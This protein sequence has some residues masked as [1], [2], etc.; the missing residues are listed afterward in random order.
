MNKMMKVLAVC[1]AVLLIFWDIFTL[2]DLTSATSGSEFFGILMRAMFPCGLLFG[3]TA[4]LSMFG[5][6]G[7][8]VLA[9]ITAVLFGF[10]AVIRLLGLAVQ[11]YEIAEKKIEVTQIEMLFTIEF[12]AY[13]LLAVAAIF[14]IFYIIKGVLRRTTLVLFSISAI[15]LLVSW[16]IMIWDRVSDMIFYGKSFL[17]I[18]FLIMT[19]DFIWSVTSLLA[20]TI[21]FGWLTKELNDTPKQQEK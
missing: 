10:N 11:F 4:L 9:V 5:R 12:F 14:L 13:F 8:N 16:G 15:T 18:V 1:S 3:I 20:Y 19:A 7:K 21:C 2:S 17:E 6:S